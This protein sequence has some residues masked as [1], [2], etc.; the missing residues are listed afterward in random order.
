M[1]SLVFIISSLLE[2][3]TYPQAGI[4]KMIEYH[5]Y[6]SLEHFITQCLKNGN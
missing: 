4:K 3:Q 1:Q 2:F 5:S 6:L